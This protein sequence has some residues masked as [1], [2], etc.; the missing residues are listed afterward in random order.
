MSVLLRALATFLGSAFLLFAG[1]TGWYV[2]NFQDSSAQPLYRLR[3]LVSEISRAVVNENRAQLDKMLAGLPF[4]T[5]VTDADG[6]IMGSNLPAVSAQARREQARKALQDQTLN[7]Q[8]QTPDGLARIYYQQSGFWNPVLWFPLIFSLLLGL[9]LS[10]W[11]YLKGTQSEEPVGEIRILTRQAL[12]ETDPD[13]EAWEDEKHRLQAKINGLQKQLETTEQLLEQARLNLHQVRE[14][15]VAS[16]APEALKTLEKELEQARQQLKRQGESHQLHEQLEKHWHEKQEQWQKEQQAL[17]Q[18]LREQ[19][20]AQARLQ[21]QNTRLEDEL[22]Q[23]QLSER[24]KTRQLEQNHARLLELEDINRQLYE[25]YQEIEKLRKSELDLMRREDLWHKEKQKLLGVLGEREQQLDETRNRLSQSRVKLRELSVAYKRQLELGLNMPDDLIEARNLLEHLI[26]DKDVVEQ[27][28]AQLQVELGDKHSEINRLRK[29]LETRATHLQESER[30]LEER[31]KELKKLRLELELVGDTLSDKL[32]DLDRLSRTHSE[33]T[34]ALEELIQE[35]DQLKTRLLDL[36]TRIEALNEEKALLLFEKDTLAEKLEGIDI[37][38]YELQI[39][40][41]KQSLQVM[42][43]QQQRKQQAI[44]TLKEKL[45]QGGDLYEKL[46][47]HVE[48][49]EREIAR[50]HEDLE[51]KESIIHL[52]DQKL[53]KAGLRDSVNS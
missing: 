42:G 38:D 36:E 39:E 21:K 3:P 48:G 31:E 16:A 35:R 25:A 19:E 23:A 4:Q 12:A 46:K 22:A 32:M 45:Q 1:F 24:E 30:R 15:P 28:N 29:E 10:F 51:R 2:W 6:E 26:A 47:R 7:S 11:D 50:L 20:L 53:D 18:N 14:H 33:D 43:S 37:Q 40:Q 27:E 41:L 49:K 5:V 13:Q 44:Q 34:L 8:L 9:C 17:R 52:L